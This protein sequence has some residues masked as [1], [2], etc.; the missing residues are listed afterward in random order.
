MTSFTNTGIARG[1]ICTPGSGVHRPAFIRVSNDGQYDRYIYYSRF[2]LGHFWS[3]IYLHVI[4]NSFI[5]LGRHDSHRPTVQIEFKT[6]YMD[7]KERNIS[8]APRFGSSLT[9]CM[10]GRPE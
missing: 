3:N 6:K 8:L 5:P 9:A 7:I 2:M 1:E 10:P 4:E